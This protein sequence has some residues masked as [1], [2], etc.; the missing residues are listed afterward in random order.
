MGL[1]MYLKRE[2][3]VKNWAFNPEEKRFDI[4]VKRGGETY[5]NINFDKISSISEDI[6]YWRKFNALHNWIV[7]NCANGTDE[8]QSIDISK[9]DLIELYN[10]LKEVNVNKDKAEELLP[11]TSGFFFGGTDYDEYYFDE[12]KRTIEELRPYIQDMEKE[13][14]SYFVYQAS[15]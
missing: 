10:T 11:T 8:C 3:Y 4:T 7:T 6:M 12:V 9:D 13:D 1:D 2:H 14:N 5:E 15:W